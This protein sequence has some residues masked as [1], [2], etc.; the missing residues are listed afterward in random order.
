MKHIVILSIFVQTIALLTTGGVSAQSKQVHENLTTNQALTDCTPNGGAYSYAGQ[1]NNPNSHYYRHADYYHLISN[2]T[3][4][5]LPRFGT[6]QQTTEWSCGNVAALMALQYLGLA[7]NKTEWQLAVKM[8]SMIDR[9]NCTD[10][11]VAPP[12]PGT[13]RCVADYGTRLADMHHYLQGVDS[14]HIVSTSFRE[15]YTDGDLVQPGDLFPACDVGNLRPTF[16]SA[17]MFVSWLTE[18]LRA[19][20][21]VLVQWS[22]W[23]GHFVCI[24]GIDN[25]G[26]ADFIGDDTLIFAD[27]YDTTDHKQDGYTTASLVRF[28]YLWKDRAI[29]PK[30]YQLQPF[31]VLERR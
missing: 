24:I 19:L 18:Q 25:N 10:T 13:A 21:P 8:H 17:D 15:N 4:L 29:A 20:R 27:P 2:D 3:L 9:S 28:F 26:T 7:G 12:L 31:I 16:A 23:D 11:T 1:G 22:D 14:L 5:I 6:M 30:P